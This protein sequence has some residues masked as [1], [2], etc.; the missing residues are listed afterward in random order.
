M[1]KELNKNNFTKSIRGFRK[2]FQILLFL[3]FGI[4]ILFCLFI[5]PTNFAANNSIGSGIGPLGPLVIYYIIF[6][7]PMKLYAIFMFLA[8]ISAILLGLISHFKSSRIEL[9][10]IAYPFFLIGIWILINAQ[11]Y[12]LH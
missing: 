11:R 9:W 5:L 1:K 8:A 6:V 12:Q 10:I 4:V 3:G 2:V 7:Y